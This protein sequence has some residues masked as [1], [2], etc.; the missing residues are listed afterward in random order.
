MKH[1]LWAIV[2]TVCLSSMSAQGAVVS[3][4]AGDRHPDKQITEIIQAKSGPIWTWLTEW[5]E[6]LF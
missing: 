3:W 4:T 2:L 1:I 5:L 6:A